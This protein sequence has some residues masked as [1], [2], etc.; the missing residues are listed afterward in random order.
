VPRVTTRAQPAMPPGTRVVEKR[1]G[2]SGPRG[3]PREHRLGALAV[4][5][6]HERRLYVKASVE[7]AP[8]LPPP[9]PGLELLLGQS[10]RLADPVR[11]AELHG[12]LGRARPDP[13]PRRPERK[14]VGDRA[15]PPR[16]DVDRERDAAE[17]RP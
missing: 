16:V 17:D 3:C 14:L 13:V 11:V 8:A 2:R 1:V 15:N 6:P 12:E 7:A 9:V 10:G 4:P 5:V